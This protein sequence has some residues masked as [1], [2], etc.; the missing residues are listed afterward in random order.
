M[1]AIASAHQASQPWHDLRRPAGS[2]SPA[3]YKEECKAAA[4]KNAELLQG[5]TLGCCKEEHCH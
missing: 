1:S 3:C 4:K 2:Q 5:S